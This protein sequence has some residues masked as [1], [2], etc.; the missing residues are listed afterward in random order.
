MFCGEDELHVKRASTPVSPPQDYSDVEVEGGDGVGGN[1]DFIPSTE[2]GEQRP[3]DGDYTVSA[4]DINEAAS[5]V[6]VGNTTAD[7][8]SDQAAGADAGAEDINQAAAVV[9]AD[10]IAVVD[11]SDQGDGVDAGESVFVQVND[12]VPP[13]NQ[14]ISDVPIRADMHQAV[15]SDE[16]VRKE[17]VQADISM[18]SVV[19]CPASDLPAASVHGAPDAAR[20]ASE[21]P[22]ATGSEAS[23]VAPEVSAGA[24]VDP[25]VVE[26]ETQEETSQSEKRSYPSHYDS[27]L[28][29]LSK[30][31]AKWRAE[32]LSEP[33][34]WSDEQASVSDLGKDE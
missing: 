11:M 5:V 30:L 25:H 10:K 13:V 28:I 17:D 7:Y 34:T 8:L 20:T 32:D 4:E 2:Y 24:Y 21:L 23:D 26:E 19:S 16:A 12:I 29:A 18:P 6:D 1:V 22:A 15:L 14:G 27:E 33:P 3:P 31:N 9:D